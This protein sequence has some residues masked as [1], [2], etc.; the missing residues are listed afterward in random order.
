MQTLQWHFQR[1]KPLIIVRLSISGV[2]DYFFF[3]FIFHFWLQNGNLSNNSD[4]IAPSHS[5]P[6]SVMS[7]SICR[8]SVAAVLSWGERFPIIL[9]R[10]K[11]TFDKMTRLCVPKKEKPVLKGALDCQVRWVTSSPEV[12]KAHQACGVQAGRTFTP[13]KLLAEQNR[14]KGFGFCSNGPRECAQ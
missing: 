2:W 10:T 5:A 9:P 13:V 11:L 14:Q 1:S 3:T 12:L 6:D 4:W 8:W 7:T